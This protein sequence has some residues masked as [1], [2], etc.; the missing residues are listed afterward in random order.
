MDQNIHA[1]LGVCY[2]KQGDIPKARYH[3][4]NA[5]KTAKAAFPEGSQY[6]A[7]AYNDVGVFYLGIGEEEKAAEYLEKS[8]QGLENSLRA[9][10]NVT[11]IVRLSLGRAYG[12]LG[13]HEKAVDHC[14]QGQ[15]A[16]LGLFGPENSRVA[17]ATMTLIKALLSGE[18]WQEVIDLMAKPEGEAI[19]TA[20][21]PKV[22]PG[23]AGYS[24][25]KA[26]LALGDR[27]A[28]ETALSRALLDADTL[29]ENRAMVL[30]AQAE[31]ANDKG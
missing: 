27:G 12:M 11:E 19:F 6:R 2:L 28:A 7:L 26:H 5:L 24:L 3:T 17:W 30:L 25:V 9:G 23:W 14:R 20:Q 22:I 21:D 4:E 1:Y 13:Q 18:R 16:L 15:Q 29:G 31:L 8:L 10:H